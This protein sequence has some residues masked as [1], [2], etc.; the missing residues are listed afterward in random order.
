MRNLE[1]MVNFRKFMVCSFL[2]LT[3]FVLN[4][5]SIIMIIK[6]VCHSACKFV[7]LVMKMKIHKS[8]SIFDKGNNVLI[9]Q[10]IKHK[11]F[12]FF[13]SLKEGTMFTLQR[14]GW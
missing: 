7:K 2:L 3:L 6:R 5:V 9:L 12:F 13:Q 8:G 11:V 14:Q 4:Q 1:K 10:T